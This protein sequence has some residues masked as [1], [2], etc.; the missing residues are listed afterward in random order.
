MVRKPKTQPRPDAAAAIPVPEP[1]TPDEA[2]I[3]ARRGHKPKAAALL[4]A[5]PSTASTDGAKADIPTAAPTKAPGRK[6]PGRKPKQAA[7]AGA[8]PSLQNGAAGPKGQAPGQ[9]EAEAGSGLTGGEALAAAAVPQAG[10]AADSNP[11]Q[12]A[13]DPVSDAARSVPEAE[14]VPAAPAA[15]WDRATDRVRFDWPTI[16]R[17]AAQGGPNQAMAKLL[18]AARAEGAQSRW[19]F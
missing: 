15:H 4:S 13:R 16:G 5:P 6:G 12:P 2:A 18:V 1:A 17:V 8:A 10:T 19:P 3:P 11:V 14:A 9:P 7:D